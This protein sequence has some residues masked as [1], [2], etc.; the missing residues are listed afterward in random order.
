MRVVGFALM[1]VLALLA[2]ASASASALPE[3]GRCKVSET[4]EGRYTNSSCTAK[5]KK[6]GE[7]FTGEFEW[8]NST[9]FGSGEAENERKVVSEL[10]QGV[11]AST[12][13]ATFIKCMPSEEKLSKCREGETE[14][15]QPLDISCEEAAS[16]E[17]HGRKEGA[18]EMTGTFSPKSDKELSKVQWKMDNCQA[19]GLVCANNMTLSRTEIDTN[20]LK[21]VLGYVKKGE[22]KEVGIDYKPESGAEV[23]KFSCG[24]AMDVIIGGAK[25]KEGPAHPPKGGGG[26][27]IATVTPINEM[28]QGIKQKL[29]MNTET[30]ENVPSSF[31]G[32]PLQALESWSYDP[33]LFGKGS[34]WSPASVS[35]PSAT[36]WL[37]DSC[38][39]GEDPA[40]AA[41]IKA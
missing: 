14:Q 26:A 3:F 20:P 22:A 35:G 37:C 11:P 4:H 38:R 15:Q 28:V 18:G 25:E 5:A 8:H 16:E 10:A 39:K 23:A 21:G 24:G 31:E 41:E 29:T 17:A 30:D 19:M 2:W 1:G 27:V 13:A 40:G 32:K 33:E 12:I 36:L 6:V 34:K 7:K 9:T